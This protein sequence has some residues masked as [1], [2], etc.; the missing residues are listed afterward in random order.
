MSVLLSYEVINDNVYV[1]KFSWI[2]NGIS[3]PT[4]IAIKDCD[5]LLNIEN[6]SEKILLNFLLKA[7]K[8]KKK[9]E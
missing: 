7:K 9:K 8:K 1:G 2:Y 5:R 4:L 6:H 3:S